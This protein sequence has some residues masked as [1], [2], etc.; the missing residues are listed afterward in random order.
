MRLGTPLFFLAL[1]ITLAGAQCP[2]GGL[3]W[4]CRECGFTATQAVATAAA[5]CR[6]YEQWDV[7]FRLRLLHIDLIFRVSRTLAVDPAHTRVES[8][9]DLQI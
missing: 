2:Q 1:R 5:E 3:S 9:A 8:T 4:E 7:Y 6:A